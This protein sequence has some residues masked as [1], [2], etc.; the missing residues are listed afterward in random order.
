VPIA[1]LLSRCDHGDI[2]DGQTAFTTA[3]GMIDRI[4]QI[5]PPFFTGG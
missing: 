2:A 4:G 3:T 5:L 1:A